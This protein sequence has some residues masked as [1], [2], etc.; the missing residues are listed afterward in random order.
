MSMTAHRRSYHMTIGNKKQQVMLHMDGNHNKT[1]GEV[2]EKNMEQREEIASRQEYRGWADIGSVEHSQ[3]DRTSGVPA[4]VMGDRRS[5]ALA[6][7]PVP[8]TAR[9]QELKEKGEI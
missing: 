6:Q 4:A 5:A 9:L 7:T 1:E 3:W 2:V 8:L